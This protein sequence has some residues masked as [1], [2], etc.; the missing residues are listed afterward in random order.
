MSRG[1]LE[2]FPLPDDGDTRYFLAAA[3]SSFDVRASV[4]LDL[5]EFSEFYGADDEVCGA[6]EPILVLTEGKTDAD[7]LERALRLL[8]PHA[9]EFYSFMDFEGAGLEGGASRVVH[10]T[11]AFVAAKM[12]H[13]IVA[14]FDNDTAGIKEQRALT[15][16]RLPAHVRALRLPDIPQNCSYPTVGPQENVR[17]NVNGLAASLELYFPPSTVKNAGGKFEPVQWTGYDQKMKRYQGQ[18]INKDAIQH[19]QDKLLDLCKSH[20]AEISKHDWSGLRAVFRLLFGA[21]ATR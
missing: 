16:R 8:Y 2:G 5:A 18:V 3:L 13:R 6:P 15:V 19:R 1:F 14:L 9:Y 4:R 7:F 10:Y 11:R 12:R 20:P 21:F 17:M